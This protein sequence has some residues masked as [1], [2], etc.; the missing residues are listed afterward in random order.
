MKF[1]RKFEVL[2]YLVYLFTIPETLLRNPDGPNA[3]V[4]Y[5]VHKDLENDRL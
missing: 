2:R 1:S 5:C 3:R 4:F